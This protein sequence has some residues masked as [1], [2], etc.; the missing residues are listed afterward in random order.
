M[1]NAQHF[2]INTPIAPEMEAVNLG[3]TEGRP[4]HNQISVSFNRGRYTLQIGN[5]EIKGD[6]FESH[7]V[8][9]SDKNW[10][11]IGTAGR[12]SAK[13]LE[14]IKERLKGDTGMISQYWNQYGLDVNLKARI[15]EL[16]K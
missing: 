2:R 16:L 7:I 4:T 13:V 12:F 11:P 9:V 1:S 6:G 8:D 15:M 10:M 14:G 5:I 3:H